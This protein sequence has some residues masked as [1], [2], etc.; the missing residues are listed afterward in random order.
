VKVAPDPP[1][2]NG[3]LRSTLSVSP[4]MLGSSSREG[5]AVP[6]KVRQILHDGSFDAEDLQRLQTAF[7]AAWLVVEPQALNDRERARER[8]AVIIVNL[9]RHLEIDELKTTAFV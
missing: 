8:L 3:L 6:M 1:N 7:D 5:W 4:R 9:D 2:W